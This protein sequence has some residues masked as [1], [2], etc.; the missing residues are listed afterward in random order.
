MISD[1]A[2]KQFK[3]IW[4]EEF[5]SDIPDE[6]AIEQAT[7]LLVLFNAAY[8]PIK[9]EWQNEYDNEQYKTNHKSKT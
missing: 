5:G 2:L 4:K 6:L 9:K 7:N 3:S 1:K 8:K